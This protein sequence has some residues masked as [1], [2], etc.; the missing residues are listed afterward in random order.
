MVG[1]H[2]IFF[3]PIGW[4]LCTVLNADRQAGL[5]LGNGYICLACLNLQ[6][7]QFSAA[8][9][10]SCIQCSTWYVWNLFFGNFLR[11]L[12]QL[13][14]SLLKGVRTFHTWQKNTSYRPSVGVLN[15]FLNPNIFL[16][17]K[18]AKFQN[19]RRTCEVYGGGERNKKNNT[20]VQYSPRAALRLKTYK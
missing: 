14:R 1:V 20:I 7:E 19:P 9:V 3:P 17:L 5:K 12:I 16:W 8:I 11:K 4:T 10:I 15:Y 2:I 18:T 6:A 13:W